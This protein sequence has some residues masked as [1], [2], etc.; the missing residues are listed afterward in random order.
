MCCYVGR[1]AWGS[2]STGARAFF[3]EKRRQLVRKLTLGKPMAVPVILACAAVLSTA[4]A[5][6]Y[7]KGIDGR[8]AGAKLATLVGRGVRGASTA[9]VDVWADGLVEARPDVLLYAQRRAMSRGE[10]AYGLRP[11]WKKREM[12]EGAVP[13]RGSVI[14][15]RVDEKGDERVPYE[16]AIIDGSL[17]ALGD[18][19]VGEYRFRVFAVRAPR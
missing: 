17:V 10:G 5:R 11:L 2:P 4:A 15:L 1:G 13:P 12:V 14:V 9:T 18:G 3:S 19:E 6:R 16:S 8:E 7:Q